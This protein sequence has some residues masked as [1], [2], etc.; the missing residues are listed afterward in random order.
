MSCRL[1]ESL[2]LWPRSHSWGI[3]GIGN[4]DDKCLV[5]EAMAWAHPGGEGNTI[6][7]KCYNASTS[8]LSV[9]TRDELSGIWVLVKYLQ[10]LKVL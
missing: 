4:S 3:E 2:F 1:Q 5:E 7:G 6:A 8:E 9:G 10:R